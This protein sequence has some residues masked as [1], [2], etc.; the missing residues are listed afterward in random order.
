MKNKVIILLSLI[1][2]IVL[3]LFLWWFQAIKPA[4]PTNKTPNLFSIDHGEDVRKIADRLENQ[5]LI[6]SPLAFFLMARITGMGNKI[7]AGDFRLNPSMNLSQTL[8]TLMHGT[9]DVWLTIPEGWRNEEIALKLAKDFNIPENEFLKYAKEGYM[10][11]DTYL[12]PK[13]TSGEKIAAIMI[14]NFNKKIDESRLLKAKQKG[15]NKEELIKISSLVE[16][17][18]KFDT[19][20]PLVASVILNRLNLNMSLD[21]DAT[22]QYVLGYQPNEKSWW[23]KDLTSEDVQ[24]DSPYNTYKNAGLPPSPICNPGLAVIDATLNAPDGNY[25][26]YLSDKNGHNHYATNMEEHNNNIVKYLNK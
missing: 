21:I 10:F 6:R 9:T 5:G 8:N 19:D 25:I 26:Y 24:I 12:I 2:T 15:L 22:V 16:R 23:K 11:P 1:L 14:D 7:Q 4:D 18:S 3:I 20:R 17:E 13:D